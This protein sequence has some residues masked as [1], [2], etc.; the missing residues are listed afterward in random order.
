ME[1]EKGRTREGV[2]KLFFDKLEEYYDKAN[3]TKTREE[4]KAVWREFLKFLD[5][6]EKQD[7]EFLKSRECGEEVLRFEDCISAQATELGL[8]QGI[9]KWR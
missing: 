5:T 4:L 2:R 9:V 6:I 3:K 8:G 1:D 7:L